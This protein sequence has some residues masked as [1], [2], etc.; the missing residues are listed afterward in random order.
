VE[1]DRESLLRHLLTLIDHALT[2]W[3]HSSPDLCSKIHGSLIGYG[4]WVQ[5]E[6]DERPIGLRKCLGLTAEGELLLLDEQMNVQRF[7]HEHLR[8]IPIE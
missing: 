2:A 5:V 3:E 4:E 8:L 7:T 6:L 1:W